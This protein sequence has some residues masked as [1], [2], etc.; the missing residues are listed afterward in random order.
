[1][2]EFIQQLINNF[3]NDPVVGSLITFILLLVFGLIIVLP[4]VYLYSIDKESK[5]IEKEKQERL[6]K[7]H[8]INIER[9]N[10]INDEHRKRKLD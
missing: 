7:W 9:E 6:K 3:N 4:I 2:K 5:L 1:M 8:D 10:W